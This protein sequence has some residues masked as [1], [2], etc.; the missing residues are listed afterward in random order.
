LA[1]V[2]GSS[3][4]A[5]ARSLGGLGSFSSIA[6]R[7]AAPGHTQVLVDGVAMSRLGTT[8]VD[9]SRFA[10]DGFS[11]IE[12]Y[13]GG[14]PVDLGGAGVGGA[15]NLITQVG[16]AAGGE[17]W[18]VSLGGGSYGAR[19]ARVRYGDGDASAEGGIGFVVG[20]GYAGAT[21]DFSYF[22]DRGTNLVTIDDQ[23]AIR[24]NNGYDQLDAVARA[25]GRRDGLRWQGGLR[26]LAKQQG[27]P[28]ST[29]TQAMHTGLDSRGLIADAA[30]TL[31]EPG[32]N[33]GLVVRTGAYAAV[34]SQ[35][36]RDPDDEIG[37]GAQDRR[38]LTI[39]GG[40]QASVTLARGRHRG[41]GA[42]E[43]RGD[44]FRDQEEQGDMPLHTHGA[45]VG[46][47][48]AVADDIGGWNGRLAVEPA[49]RFEAM[50]SDPLVDSNA[51]GEPIDP[52]PRT[53]LFASPRLGAR[54]LVTPDLA[55]KI[56]GGR[57]TRVPTALELFGDRGFIAGRPELRSEQGWVGDGGVVWAPGRAHGPVDRLYLEAA[58]YWSNPHDAIVYVVAGGVARPINVG[59]TIQRGVELVASGRVG[60]T[61]TLS[62]NYTLL[63]ARQHAAQPSLEGKRLPGRPFH[64]FYGRV[65]V[66]RR[67]GTRLVA[68]FADASYTSGTFLDDANFA[69]VPARWLVGIGTKLE[70]G[71]GFTLAFEVKNLSDNRVETVPL[72]PPPRPDLATVPRAVAD[73]SGYPLPGRAL[74]LRLDWSR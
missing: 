54:G 73:T 47:A 63:D 62:A 48:V 32:E 6:V 34:E 51:A 49:V 69:E 39:A 44:R 38:Y 60:R 33:R 4:G 1:E 25:A 70:L 65:D 16:R 22:D 23:T 2:V 11:E 9:L 37:F 45:R 18:R 28:G 8:T 10:L 14:V 41:A 5:G 64:A 13:R 50:R 74:Y 15:L 24:T 43:V 17:R 20:L 52:D 3:V 19:S 56:T 26:G 29:S 42:V 55:V 67:L 59:E 57:Y 7:G 58:G 12:L 40:G 66:A 72:D 36:W 46:V 71:A 21:G 53:D 31:D 68:A 27:V 61:A 35:A 30:V